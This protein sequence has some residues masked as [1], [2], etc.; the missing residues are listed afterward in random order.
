MKNEEYITK[1][2]LLSILNKIEDR[3]ILYNSIEAEYNPVLEAKISIC[4]ELI[5]LLTFN[6]ILY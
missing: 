3:A 6:E 1:E 4:S 5:Q 2:E